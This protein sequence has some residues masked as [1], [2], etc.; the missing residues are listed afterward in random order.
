MSL[1]LLTLGFGVVT[2]AVLSLTSVG[3][4]LQFGVTNYVNFAYGAFLAIGMFVTYS[5]TVGLH[6]PFWIGAIIGILVTGLSAVLVDVLVLERFVRRGTSGFFLLIITFG[7]SLILLN[8][9]QAIWGVGFDRYAIAEGSPLHLGP[10]S[11]T[12][13]QLG[14]VVIAAVA[15]VAIHLLLT[16]TRL[17][18]AMRA[19]SDN[20]PLA[21][22]SGIDTG[23]T[24]LWTWFISGCLAGLGGVALALNTVEFQAFTGNSFLFVIFAAVILGGIG[25]IYG[26]MVGAVIIGIVVSLSSLV[27]SSAYNLD[28]AFAVLVLTLLIRPQGIF[29]TAGKA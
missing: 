13:A 14:V 2:S 3:L 7:L 15:M 11:V 5:T 1:F 17:G 18:M 6:L 23:R 4:S 16:R 25:K 22:A 28:V 29:A 26:A 8:L 20:T 21:Q 19:M 10:F 27:I 24:T 12:A 9:V